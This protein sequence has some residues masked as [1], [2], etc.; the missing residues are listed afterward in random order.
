MSEPMKKPHTDE[1]IVTLNLRVR[2]SIAVKVKQ[3]VQLLEAEDKPAYSVADVFPEYMDKK[4]Q[5]ALRAYRTRESLTQKE[6]SLKTGIPQHQISEMENGKRG[7]GKE[8]ARKL[9]HA[10]NVSDYRYFL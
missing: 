5:T 9:A 7:I 8:R 6:L 4:P 1:E 3:Y 2:R 10:L